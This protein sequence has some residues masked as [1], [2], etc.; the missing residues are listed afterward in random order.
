MGTVISDLKKRFNQGSLLLQLIYI[1]VGVFVL[2]RLLMVVLTLFN[3]PTAEW[4]TYIELSSD[5]YN[6]LF[7]PWT[8]FTYMFLHIEAIHILFNMLW[9]YW[10]GQMFLQYFNARQMGGLYFLGGIAGAFLYILS[11]NIFPYFVAIASDSF[12]IG[13]SASILAI[14]TAVA[15]Y[16]PNKEVNL[17]LIGRI[18]IKWIAVFSILI[19]LLSITSN[20]AGGNIA[21]LGGAFVGYLFAIRIA[22]GKDVTASLNKVI[23]AV[24]NIFKP[25]PK[26]KVTYKRTETDYQYNSRKQEKEANINAI[27]ERIKRSGYSSLTAEEKK[28]LFEAGKN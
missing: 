24:V 28:R 6:L 7:R 23:D 20:N 2:L 10:F 25:R 22:Q 14:V 26:L 16:V 8:L 11:Y 9:L 17:L 1:N 5:P 19:D 15:F 12:L 3:I 21:H 13:A 27:L 4:L 18:K